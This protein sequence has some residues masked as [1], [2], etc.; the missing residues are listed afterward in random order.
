MIFVI[1]SNC[2]PSFS[3]SCIFDIYCKNECLD[4]VSYVQQNFNID[5]IF[6]VDFYLNPKDL[7]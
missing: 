5:F 6:A 1:F 4:E 3:Y 7:S 2:Q